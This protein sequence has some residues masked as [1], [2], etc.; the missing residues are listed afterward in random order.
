[1]KKVEFE[2]NYPNLTISNT[3]SES[4]T[5]SEHFLLDITSKTQ[6]IAIKDLIFSSY[7]MTVRNGAFSL[8][9]SLV[10]VKK[11]ERERSL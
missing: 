5:Y 6:V 3:G 4:D 2:S 9:N 1:M 8:W 7:L 10:R 11:H